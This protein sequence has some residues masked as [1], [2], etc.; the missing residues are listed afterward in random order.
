MPDE[1]ESNLLKDTV[2]SYDHFKQAY[3]KVAQ[4][5]QKL[6]QTQLRFEAPTAEYF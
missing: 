5:K 1:D 3:E 6:K 2:Y 4:A